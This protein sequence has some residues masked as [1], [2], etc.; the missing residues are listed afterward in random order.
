MKTFFFFVLLSSSFSAFANL[1]EFCRP[2]VEEVAKEFI[3]YKDEHCDEE[4]ASDTLFL[5]AMKRTH[6]ENL[7]KECELEVLTGKHVRNEMHLST[8]IYSVDFKKEAVAYFDSLVTK[9]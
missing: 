9:E 4:L 7:G 1:P 5:E 6:V 3:Q 2:R 8:D